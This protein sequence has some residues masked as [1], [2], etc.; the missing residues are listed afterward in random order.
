[1]N[2][3]DEFI[4]GNICID[5]SR[6]AFDVQELSNTFENNGIQIIGSRSA[7]EYI[8][9]CIEENWEVLVYENEY[10]NAF[11][12][13]LANDARQH[14]CVYYPTKFIAECKVK[15]IEIEENSLD[16]LFELS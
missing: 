9:S 12:G 3:I 2:T 4:K 7:T 1:M 15:N 5:I 16:E 6:E 13:H 11:R 10:L 14:K 8:E